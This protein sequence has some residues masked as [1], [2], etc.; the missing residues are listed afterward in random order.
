MR[1]STHPAT[2]PP[3]V[4]ITETRIV[5]HTG[6]VPVIKSWP[7]FL[8]SVDVQGHGRAGEERFVAAGLGADDLI[9]RGVLADPASED[10]AHDTVGGHGENDSNAFIVGPALG[11]AQYGGV[12]VLDLHEG[13]SERVRGLGGAAGRDERAPHA[14]RQAGDHPF[15]VAADEVGR[16][17][18]DDARTV[19]RTPL[20]DAAV[21]TPRGFRIAEHGVRE[22]VMSHHR[23]S[24]PITAGASSL[25]RTTGNRG[26]SCWT[27]GHSSPSYT[28]KA[29]HG[30]HGDA[31]LVVGDHGDRAVGGGAEHHSRIREVAQIRHSGSFLFSGMR[32]ATPW[33]GFRENGLA[34]YLF[35]ACL[36]SSSASLRC[37]VAT[38]RC[39]LM[40]CAWLM[41]SWRAWLASCVVM[42][43][44]T[45]LM[46]ACT[47]FSVVLSV[48]GYL[49][50]V[51]VCV[52]SFRN[53]VLAW[54]ISVACSESRVARLVASTPA[55]NR[56][57]G[58]T[59]SPA[60][61]SSNARA[62]ARAA[63]ASYES[64]M[65]VASKPNSRRVSA[66]PSAASAPFA[67]NARCS[68]AART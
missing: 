64:T 38:S 26:R 47:G 63:S 60:F 62:A 7:S 31:L 22:P 29:F 5:A 53:L 20:V 43:S 11:M 12:G 27:V 36:A 52:T 17:P 2:V 39:R 45:S 3:H 23:R 61:G 55:G 21:E 19:R 10:E 49:L 48:I 1:R 50:S 16:M 59:G 58:S 25:R 66:R 13:A 18:Q 9:E 54:A 68:D 57:D 34:D 56:I 15:G 24:P 35:S 32:K 4:V 67:L 37:R 42:L 44:S 14:R 30:G 33:G 65:V 51:M 6:I 46:S 28:A 41:A 8:S 40:A